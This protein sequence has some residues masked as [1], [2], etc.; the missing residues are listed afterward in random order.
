[1]LKVTA[2]LLLSSAEFCI[3]LHTQTAFTIFETDFNI[4]VVAL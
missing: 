4:A 3:L 2:A 1:M